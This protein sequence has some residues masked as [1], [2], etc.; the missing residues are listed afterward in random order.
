MSRI[1]AE[2]FAGKG[3]RT[4]ERTARHL[5][6]V[7]VT[8]SLL[9]LALIFSATRYDPDLHNLVWKQAAALL[10]GLL[11]CLLLPLLDLRGLLRRGWWLLAVGNAAL[12]LLLLPFGND[13]GTGNR[14]WLALPGGVFNLQPAELVKVGFL[15]LLALQLEHR[16]QSGLNRPT[17]VLLLALHGLGTAGLV[18]AVSGDMGMTAVFLALW[19][20]MLWSGGLHPLWLAVILLA[21]VGSAAAL[22]SHLPDYVRLRFLVVLDH[23]LD[24]LGKGFQQ[25]RSLLALGSGRLTGLGYLRGTQTQSSSASALPARHTDFIFSAAGEEFGL[26]GCMI[27]VLLLTSV[28]FLCVRLARTAGDPIFRDAAMGAATLFGV[29]TVL[30]LGMC[31]YAAPVVGVTLPFFSYGGSSLISSFLLVGVLRGLAHKTV[32]GGYTGSIREGKRRHPHVS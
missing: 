15:F 22:W 25:G 17:S 11:L 16:R 30:N 7:C 2:A 5:L 20:G 26:L 21:G 27:L 14:S 6:L 1:V 28:L 3:E 4:L 18:Y 24:P 13:D 8:A 32:P 10:F 31:L 9:G 23:D 19:L 12:L 29:Q